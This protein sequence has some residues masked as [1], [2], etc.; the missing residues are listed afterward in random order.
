MTF[1]GKYKPVVDSNPAVGQYEPDS[2]HGLTK[3]RAQAAII[4]E[5]S[6]YK[7]QRENSP[8]PG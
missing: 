6:G 8:A 3:P 1:G 7:V 2:A 5:E 4:R